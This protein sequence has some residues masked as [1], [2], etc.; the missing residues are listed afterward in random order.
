M[1]DISVLKQSL[2]SWSLFEI[3]AAAVV[4]TGVVLVVLTQFESFGR[5]FS[6]ERLPRWHAA[7]GGL[8]VLLVILGLAGE[9]I[10][11]T[12]ARV[13]SDQISVQLTEQAAAAIARSKAMEKDAA[14]L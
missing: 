6:L 14:E 7:M 8:G 10:A 13:I 1:D 12:K 2:A 3:S 9:I 11:A 4:F 5:L